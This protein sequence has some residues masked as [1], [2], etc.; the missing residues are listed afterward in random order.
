MTYPGLP[1]DRQ[2][3]SLIMRQTYD[4]L[5][6]FVTTLE[7]RA[8]HAELMS[9]AEEDRPAFV[10]EVLLRHEELQRRGVTVPDGI[11]I[12]TSVFGDRRP[13]LFAVK[14]SSREVPRSVG[15]S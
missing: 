10:I 9:L 11:L 4:E 15:E 14:K 7:F 6:E 3:L 2:E 1:F 12:E 8:I 13:T 5:I